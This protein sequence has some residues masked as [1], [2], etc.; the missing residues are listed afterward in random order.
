M[1]FVELIEE[2][3][4]NGR[5]LPPTGPDGYSIALLEE[6]E[7]DDGLMDL[8]L[9]LGEE[10]FLAHRLEVLRPLNEGLVCVAAFAELYHFL[11][12]RISVYNLVNQY[13]AY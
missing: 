4:Y 11:S 1:F 8:F 7:L 10:T 5:V 2:V 12:L 3:G 9:E 13:C 6:V